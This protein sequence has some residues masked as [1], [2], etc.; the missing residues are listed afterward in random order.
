MDIYENEGF[1]EQRNKNSFIV[2]IAHV[3][4]K[5]TKSG[6]DGGRHRRRPKD[7]QQTAGTGVTR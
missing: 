5:A 4:Q 7:Q 2:R 6:G 1:D 3:V